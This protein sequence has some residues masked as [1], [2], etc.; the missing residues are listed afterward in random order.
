MEKRKHPRVNADLKVS[1]RSFDKYK[2]SLEDSKSK[3]I[4]EGGMLIKMPRDG[5]VGSKII[6]KFSLPDNDEEILVRGKIAWVENINAQ[7]YNIG[8]EFLNIRESDIKKIKGY[9]SQKS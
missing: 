9:I 1:G 3:N 7:D 5:R 2:I 6:V 4:S 8:I